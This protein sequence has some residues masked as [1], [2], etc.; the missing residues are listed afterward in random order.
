MT[1]PRY[2]VEVETY[3]EHPLAVLID[4]VTG[5]EVATEPV[6]TFPYSE[7]TVVETEPEGKER[8]EELAAK[9]NAYEA[10]TQA[11]A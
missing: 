1:K 2:T 9:L 8:L 6:E 7:G 5:H 4:N 10:S 3:L 11:T